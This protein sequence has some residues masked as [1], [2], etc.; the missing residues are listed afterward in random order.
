M[1]LHAALLSA[2]VVG[3]A[4]AGCLGQSNP[5]A[6]GDQGV[7]PTSDGGSGNATG[8]GGA[9]A[10][11]TAGNATAGAGGSGSAG[12]SAPTQVFDKAEMWTVNPPADEKFSLS[13]PAAKLSV[14]VTQDGNPGAGSGGI[15]VQV[16]GKEAGKGSISF[17]PTGDAKAPFE[18]SGPIAAGDVTIKFDGTAV[19][20]AHITITAS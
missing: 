19:G 1:R 3:L 18:V 4:L 17:A 9:G 8:S 10:N 13:K 15:S 7:S 5:P 12:A 16:G 6:A 11:V 20:G 14:N 2:L